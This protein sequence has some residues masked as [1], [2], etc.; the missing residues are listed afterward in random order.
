MRGDV[1]VAAFTRCQRHHMHR[2]CSRRLQ[3]QDALTSQVRLDHL[4]H[5]L[6]VDRRA[7]E[8]GDREHPLVRVL[9]RDAVAG[10]LEQ[11]DVVL[12]VAE[13]DRLAPA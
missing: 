4:R 5:A 11:L 12:A 1:V 8:V 2:W 9:D 6:L 13:G 7:D 3:P 10:P